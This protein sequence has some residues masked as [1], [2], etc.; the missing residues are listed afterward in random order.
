LLIKHI[1]VLALAFRG[2]AEDKCALRASALTFLTLLSIVP[3]FALVFAVAKGF[4]LDSMLEAQLNKAFHGNEEVLNKILEFSHRQLQITSGGVVAG[5]GVVFLLMTV[6][7]LLGNIEKAF[8]EIWGVRKSRSI[9]RKLA[10]Y[11]LIMFIAPIFLVISGSLTAFLSAQPAVLIEKYEFLRFIGPAMVMSIKFFPFIILWTLFSF[12]YAFIPNTKVRV[13]PMLV[14]GLAAAVI[15]HYAQ[16]F[17]FWIQVKLFVKYSAIYGS[18]ATFP[19]FLMWLEFSWMIVLFGAEIAFATQNSD[20][21]EFEQDSRKASR[22]FRNLAALYILDYIVERF[23]KESPPPSEEAIIGELE[24]PARLAR[25]VLDDLEKTGVIARVL[26]DDD[27]GVTRYQP[28]I[29]LEEITAKRVLDRLDGLGVDD[30]PLRRNHSLHVLEDA[31]KRMAKA[32]EKSKGNIQLG[33][34]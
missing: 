17:Y 15:F 25:L 18:L 19:L 8:N 29:P 1:R 9:G 27:D 24:V 22:R 21:Y 10:D 2:F 30:I 13:I 33:G 16:W 28:A 31:V 3:I 11:L 34:V 12:I 23:R 32:A 6:L 4:S 14:S 7:K 20:T 5:I 26:I